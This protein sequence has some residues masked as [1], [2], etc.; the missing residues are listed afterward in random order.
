MKIELTSEELHALGQALSYAVINALTEHETAEYAMLKVKIEGEITREK[1]LKK[2]L[3]KHK[4]L[5]CPFN[6]CDSN[7][8]CEGKCHYNNSN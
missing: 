8:P 6:Y 5:G 7:P 1:E 3:E 4:S 2:R